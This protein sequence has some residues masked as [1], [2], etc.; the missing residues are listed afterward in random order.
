MATDLISVG[1]QPLSFPTCYLTGPTNSP[2]PQAHPPAPS[3]LLPALSL[4][5]Q[6]Y[7]LP[8]PSEESGNDAQISLSPPQYIQSAT[9]LVNSS[10]S[11]VR[12]T[13]LFPF[14]LLLT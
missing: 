11:V 12:S 10:L 5:Q 9:S 3:T 13:P 14:S 7:G 6:H 1:P 8:G 4:G 2:L